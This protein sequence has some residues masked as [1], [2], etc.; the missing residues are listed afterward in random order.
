MTFV[1]CIGGIMPKVYKLIVNA[2][3]KVSEKIDIELIYQLMNKNKGTFTEILVT[4]IIATVTNVIAAREYFQFGEFVTEILNISNFSIM[5]MWLGIVMLALFRIIYY[6]LEKFVIRIHTGYKLSKILMDNTDDIFSEIKD[7][8]G[9]SWGK[10]KTLMCC[11]NLIKGWTS[12]QIVIDCVTSHKKKSSEWLSD[13]NWE[14]EYIEYMSGSSAEKIISH[15]NNNQRWMIEDIQQNYSKNDKKIFISLQ[16]TDYCTTSFVW[17]KFRSK[18]EHSKKLVQQ[19]FSIKKGSYLPHSFCLHLVIVTSDKKV[20]TTVISNNKSNDYA[21]SIAVT[22]GEQIEDT[23]FNNNTGFCDNFVERWVI[24][25][26]NEEFGI[27][28][29]QYEYI[30]GKDSISVLAFDFEGDI[31]N[32]SLM[33]VLNLT[34]T[35]DQFAREVNRNPEKDKEYDEMKGLNLKKIPYILW[36]GDKLENGKYVYH[37]SSYLRL[38]LTYIHYYGIKKFVK[39]YEKAGK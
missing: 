26:L 2:V 21:G 30:T 38:Y 6:I 15:R 33:T 39:E 19:V 1:K 34:V 32:I 22:L 7:Y 36:L 4:Y 24:R 23:D 37:P 3:N 12:K 35:Y 14:Q 11:D 9:Y 27:D 28:A 8:G 5:L 17:N 25:A 20:V 31:Y 29:S 10:N 16:K 13:N 18:D